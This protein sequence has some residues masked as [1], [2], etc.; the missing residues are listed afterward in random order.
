M[1]TDKELIISNTSAIKKDFYQIYPEILEIVQ[2][3]SERW[4]PQTS[5]ESDPGVVLLKILAFIADKNNYNIDK[6]VLEA[7]MPSASQEES[8]RKLCDMMGYDM[9][10][11]KSATTSIKISYQG[12]LLGTMNDPSGKELRFKAFDTVFTNE[13]EDI[14]Y[15]LLDDIILTRKYQAKEANIIEGSLQTCYS[16]NA[17]DSSIIKLANLDDNNRFYFPERMIAQNGI[18]VSSVD[19]DTIDWRQVS[20]LNTQIS[21]SKVWKFGFDSKENLPY[22]QFPDDIAELIGDGFNIKYIR[23]LGV[24]GNVSA[25]SLI[26]IVNTE[27]ANG[28]SLTDDNEVSAMVVKNESAATNGA[29]KETI[30]QAY[31]NFKKTVGTFDTLVSCRDYANKIYQLVSSSDK[32]NPLVS[33]CQVSDI[34]DDINRASSVMTFDSYGISFQDVPTK[35][36]GKDLINHFDLYLYPFAAI[37]GSYTLDSYKSSFLPTFATLDEIK[38]NLEEYKT[39]SHDIKIPEDGDICAIKNF[40]K[41]NAKITTTYKVNAIEE[42][43]ILKNIYIALYKNFN[44]RYIDF[45]EEI[46]Y[47]NILKVIE[48]A[49]VRIK[50]VSLDEPELETK[51]TILN[52]GT[53]VESDLKTNRAAYIKMLAKNILAGKIPLLDYDTRFKFDYTEAASDGQSTFGGGKTDGTK[54]AKIDT[55]VKITPIANSSYALRDNE[56]IQFMAPSLSTYLTYPVYTNYYFDWKNKPG[57][58][59][60]S[61][62]APVEIRPFPYSQ[63]INTDDLNPQ[64]LAYSGPWYSR[65]PYTSGSSAT[66]HDD[67]YEYKL[68]DGLAFDAAKEYVK[69]SSTNPVVVIGSAPASQP[70]SANF[71]ATGPW[72]RKIPNTSGQVGLLKSKSFTYIRDLNYQESAEYGKLQSLGSDP[73]PVSI[74]ANTEYKLKSGDI[75]YINYTDSSGKV[76]NIEYHWDKIITNGQEQSKPEGVIIR[77]NF[78]LQDSNTYKLNKRFSKKSG[79]KETWNLEGM[80]TLATNEQIELRDFVKSQLKEPTL[81]YWITPDGKIPFERDAT[82]N[83]YYYILKEGEYFFYTNEAKS[84]LVTLGSGTKLYRN[85]DVTTSPIDM[86]IDYS[87]T[88]QINIDDVSND[89]I[90]AFADNP[91]VTLK[92]NGNDYLGI[93]EMQFVTLSAKDQLISIEGLNGDISNTFTKIDGAT[94]ALYGQSQTSLPSINVDALKWQVRSRLDLNVGPNLR[95]EILAGQSIT[96][97]NLSGTEMKKISPTT[98]STYIKCNYLIQKAGGTNISTLITFIDSDQTEIQDYPVTFLLLNPQDPLYDRFDQGVEKE[99]NLVLNTQTYNDNYTKVNLENQRNIRLPIVIPQL[100]ENPEFGMIMIYY[101]PQ[102]DTGGQV[103]VN[104]TKA[105]IRP[106]NQYSAQDIIVSYAPSYTLNKGINVLQIKESTTLTITGTSGTLTFSKLAVVNDFNGTNGVDV[107]NLYLSDQ[108]T[109]LAD[110]EYYKLLKE[111]KSISTLDSQDIFYYNCDLDNSLLIDTPLNDPKV[112]YDYNNVYN[113][114]VISELDADYFTKGGISLTKASKL[115]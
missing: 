73:I 53:G 23:T 16:N 83:Q 76:F 110:A 97:Y 33:N 69:L 99:K 75:L 93:Q 34:R 9:G 85:A 64:S 39:I 109:P 66:I 30:E 63:P 96:F 101:E 7:F 61:G 28:N 15:V 8:M 106:Y 55:E 21:G 105:C 43:A 60:V 41:L 29:D 115:K 46:P 38:S 37:T 44:L 49:D 89:G 112:F 107:D 48:Q 31:N 22:I 91:W 86:T 35:K 70:T 13:D 71:T 74:Q 59:A 17:H 65:K 95:Q 82:S 79:F 84:S 52:N 40:Y 6:N 14:K 27:D 26:K 113:K 10:Y 12:T 98:N 94:Y 51:Y 104:S 50:N 77:P 100:Q 19:S 18:F 103:S 25:G 57:T 36:N 108:I 1:I 54:I 58:E 81:C 68:E 47:E 87:K 20:N 111:I 2:K 72:Y 88:S 32:S 67:Q 24:N 92:F 78:D 80:F 45:G 5:N 56:V 114:F 11:Y 3:I 4:N 62:T 90:G 42:K 102:S